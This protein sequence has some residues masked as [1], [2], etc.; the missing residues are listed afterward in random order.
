MASNVRSPV[1]GSGS[2]KGWKCTLAKQDGPPK[3]VPCQV[4]LMK[5]YAHPRTSSINRTKNVVGRF[6][7][8]FGLAGGVVV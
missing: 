1:A 7:N 6:L 2:I 5:L 8:E 4:L 3:A